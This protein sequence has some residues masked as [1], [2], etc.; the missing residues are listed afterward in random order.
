MSSFSVDAFCF[1]PPPPATRAKK[2]F[3]NTLTTLLEGIRDMS[4][5]FDVNGNETLLHLHE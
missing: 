4:A 5:D 3:Q 2:V 1:A